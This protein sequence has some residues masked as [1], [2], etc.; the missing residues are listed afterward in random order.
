MEVGIWRPPM[1]GLQDFRSGKAVW[2]DVSRCTPLACSNA[3]CTKGIGAYA[4]SRM[5]GNIHQS[6]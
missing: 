3:P 2:F 4:L 1:M 5:K 6:Q